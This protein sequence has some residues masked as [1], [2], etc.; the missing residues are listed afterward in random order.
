MM[1][2]REKTKKKSR[3]CSIWPESKEIRIFYHQKNPDVRMANHYNF[4]LELVLVNL[5]KFSI[6]AGT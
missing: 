1:I 3:I 6:S 4:L 2:K 5:K